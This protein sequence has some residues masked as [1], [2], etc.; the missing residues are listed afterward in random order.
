MI[1]RPFAGLF[2]PRVAQ[3][4]PG[5]VTG[6]TTPLPPPGQAIEATAL[7]GDGGEFPAELGFKTIELGGVEHVV[8]TIFDLTGR[9]AMEAALR[10]TEAQYRSL[11][12][13]LPLNVFVKDLEGRFLFANQRFCRMTHRPLGELIGLTDFDIFP[14]PLA[15]KYRADDSHVVESESTLEQIEEY[16]EPEAGDGSMYVHV[17]KAP[18]RD[19]RGHV[20]GIQGMFWDV[21]DRVRAER[22]VAAAEARHRATLEAALDCIITADSDGSSNPTSSG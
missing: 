4:L 1:G 12:E 11:V 14:D 13:S 21:T 2:P 5:F 9:K 8:A 17:L 10:N 20:V 19:A 15:K 6:G 22:A 7:R 18:S 3:R 16:Q